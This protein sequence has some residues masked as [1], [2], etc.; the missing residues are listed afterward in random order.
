MNNQLSRLNP[1]AKSPE[2]IAQEVAAAKAARKA[3]RQAELQAF[4]EMAERQAL[5][6]AQLNAKL[7]IKRYQGGRNTRRRRLRSRRSRR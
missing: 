3:A 4:G 6:A 5:A 2:Q 7:D 1:F